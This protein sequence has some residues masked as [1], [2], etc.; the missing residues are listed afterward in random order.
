MDIGDI[1]EFGF[2]ERIRHRCWHRPEG[3]V[4][5]IGD[6]AA[7]VESDAGR[8]TLV[9]T[10][11]LLEGVHFRRAFTSGEA[12]GHKAL[13]VNLSDIAAMGG[14]PKDAFVSIAIPPD[15]DLTYLDDIYAGMGALAGQHRVN[16]LGGDTTASP[17][18]LVLNVTIT[19]S[20]A[21]DALLRRDGAR[22]GDLIAVTGFLG[23]SR[24]G[25]HLLQH[26]IA[27]ETPGHRTLL[28]SHRRPR[29][30]LAEGRFLA[31]SGRVHCAMDVS[32]GLSSDLVHIMA[33]SG[34]GARIYADR[35]PLSD[36]LR[37]VCRD[38]GL[39]PVTVAL[40]GGEDYVLLCTI[41]PAGAGPLL[42]AYRRTFGTPLQIIGEISADKGD[43]ELVTSDG[44][45]IPLPASG[46][47]HFD[48]R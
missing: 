31:S 2:I 36:E 13:A 27:L 45:R 32:D 4:V 11:L 7:A 21:K 41:D 19:G 34:V 26:G 46:W 35:L 47:D 20:A 3:V 37:A 38:H 48:R 12:L 14:T 22:P 16:I 17:K 33:Q 6:D 39:D 8:L 42:H 29:P 18:G 23:N 10:D 15:C 24:A 5:G 25:L 1:G 40:A 30:H 44:D 9:S 28:R 43:A